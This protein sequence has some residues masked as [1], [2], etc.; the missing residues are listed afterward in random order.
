MRPHV[1][2]RLAR[3]TGVLL[4]AGLAITLAATQA[5]ADG[6]LPL[7]SAGSTQNASQRGA[8][9]PPSPSMLNDQVVV[10]N[11]IVRLGDLF[12]NVPDDKAQIPVA[13][14]PE[15]G[16]QAIFDARWLYSVA[17]H[18]GINW[19][20]LSVKD[21]AV[22]VRDSIT[23]GPAEIAKR[24]HQALVDNGV[25]PSMQVAL[26][27]HMLT[28]HLPATDK[29]SQVA[30]K[31]IY[32]DP[33]TG[34]FTAIIVAPAGDPQAQHVRV[35]GRI[36]RTV[37]IPVLANR[38]MPGDII[39]KQDVDWIKVRASSLQNDTVVDIADLVGKTPTRTIA[40]D[41]PVHIRDVRNPV[42]IQRGQLV[43]VYHQTPLMTLTVQGK[44]LQNGSKGDVIRVKNTRSNTVIDAVVISSG[45]VAVELPRQL[46][47]NPEGGG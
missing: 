21:E 4:L 24:I 5:S 9:T 15:P 31:S 2:L 36:Y 10:E 8:K 6:S 1:P 43:T 40:A 25:D 29:G 23:I 12:S 33:T 18:Y 14:A 45:R 39:G 22:V 17:Q 37:Q 30:V 38:I 26:S 20:P 16:Q 41:Q 13:Y 3:L 42:L 27:N 32:H 34:H 47:M 35:T 7:L 11:R 46:A 28:L 19:Q 44:A